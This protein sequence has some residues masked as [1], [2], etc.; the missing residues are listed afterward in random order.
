MMRWFCGVAVAGLFAV[1]GMAAEDQAGGLMVVTPANW[2]R[3]CDT[4]YA[5]GVRPRFTRDGQIKRNSDFSLRIEHLGAKTGTALY[6]TP[7]PAWEGC[8]YE[9]RVWVKTRGAK[10][11]IAVRFLDDQGAYVEGPQEGSAVDGD[12]DWRE[13]RVRAIAPPRTVA[14]HV[15][16]ICRQG[17]SWFDDLSLREGARPLADNVDVVLL[18]SRGVARVQVKKLPTSSGFTV[19]C[20]R[21]GDGQVIST[22]SKDTHAAVIADLQPSKSYSIEVDAFDAEKGTT[23]DL[24]RIPFTV[25]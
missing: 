12:G 1:A 22:V 14:V 9:A 25:R 16:M 13:L 20:A 8:T 11:S 23:P 24:V 15:F 4:Y 5:A 19:T 6:Q 3:E 2:N 17:E 7:A 18:P 21:A 10:A